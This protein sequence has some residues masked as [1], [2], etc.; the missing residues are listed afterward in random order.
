MKLS[1]YENSQKKEKKR[2][3]KKCNIKV[4]RT[5]RQKGWHL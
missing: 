2:K 5:E 4:A 1:L 3:E